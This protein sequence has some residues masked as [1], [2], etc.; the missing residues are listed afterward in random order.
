MN[1]EL[2]AALQRIRLACSMVNATLAD[3]QQLLN[4]IAAIEQA[5]TPEKSEPRKK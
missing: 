1:K 3:H 5:L 4:D 2:A